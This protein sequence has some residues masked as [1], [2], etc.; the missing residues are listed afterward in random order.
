MRFNRLVALTLAGIAMAVTIY[1]GPNSL[2][3]SP[4]IENGH[5]GS[6]YKILH[7]QSAGSGDVLQC[8]RQLLSYLPRPAHHELPAV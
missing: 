3:S 7:S 5:T 8:L 4:S 1:V 6:I 2:I